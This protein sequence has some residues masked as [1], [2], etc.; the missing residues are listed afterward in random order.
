MEIK[1]FNLPFIILSRKKII[2]NQKN[3]FFDK[4]DKDFIIDI[5]I[6]L[7]LSYY[8]DCTPEEIA[9]HIKDEYGLEIEIKVIERV[10][11]YFN[12]KRYYKNTQ[13]LFVVDIE[14]VKADFSDIDSFIRTNDKYLYL[15]NDI[16]FCNNSNLIKYS[17]YYK[18]KIFIN[19]VKT[20]LNIGNCASL[21]SYKN[22]KNEYVDL[23]TILSLKRF[24]YAYNISDMDLIETYS[25]KH[26]KEFSL[27]ECNNFVINSQI[28][29]Y[30]MFAQVNKYFK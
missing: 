2:K 27:S 7:I 18:G 5:Y 24:C 10:F 15:Y 3:I 19:D 26:N 22:F 4:K 30:N 1:K 20:K 14:K 29:F 11:F 23:A 25:I 21:V 9:F 13:G 12:L 6:G 16:L 28:N 8:Y 17:I